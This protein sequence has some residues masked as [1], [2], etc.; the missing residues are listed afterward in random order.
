M[1]FIGGQLS[2]ASPN[3]SVKS[4]TQHFK[5]A[6]LTGAGSM[7]GDAACVSAQSGTDDS[8]VCAWFDNNTFGEL[9]SPNMSVS[10]LANELR[11]I[12]P[13]VEHVVK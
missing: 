11:A 7:G 1:L 9:V 3:L 2:G 5:G 6:S 10:A 13:S 4:F 8:T 12:R